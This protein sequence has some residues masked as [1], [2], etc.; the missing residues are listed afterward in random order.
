[1]G[2]QATPRSLGDKT[3]ESCRYYA[4][5]IYPGRSPLY[6]NR[7]MRVAEDPDLLEVAAE[8]WEKNA[9]PNLFFAAVHL[10][11]LKGEHHQLAAFYPSLNNTSRHY[12]YVYP[13]FRNFVLEHL[14]DIR[15]TLMAH[16]VQ[17]NEVGR[18][19]VLVPAFELVA[20]QTKRQP[21]PM[22]EIGYSAGIT[23]LWDL[24][25]YHYGEGLER[26]HRNSRVKIEC[27]LRGETRPPIPEQLPK[28]ASRTGI[29]LS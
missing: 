20:A 15:E 28:V 7:A 23:L 10:L 13:Y 3:A 18:C 2:K 22:T 17:T 14:E 16:S 19:A 26:G 4:S 29:D 27:S 25:H 5:V 21:L 11:L 6:L 24:Y 1:M 9:L 12:G 8:A